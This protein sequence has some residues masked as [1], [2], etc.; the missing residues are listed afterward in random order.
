MATFHGGQN[1]VGTALHRQVQVADQLRDFGVYL[2]QAVA[3]FQ[4]MRGGETDAVDAIDIR[5][6]GNEFGQISDIAVFGGAT[7]GVYVLTQQVYFAHAL[8]GQRLHFFQH[9]GQRAADFLTAGVGHHAEGTVF[10]A[11]FHNGDEGAAAIHFRF[12]QV[13]EF[14][15]FRKGNVHHLN[16]VG[17]FVHHIRQAVQGLR[18][19][20]H[21]DERCALDNG[22]AFLRGHTA[23]HTDLQ[24]R[25]FG[26]Q[27]FPASQLMEHFFLRF[28]TD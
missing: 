11:A 6:Q 1:A 19:E 21:V 12:R 24:I 23:T 5:H 26:F 10:G 9:I 3:E 15:D 2:N 7:V 8:T 14:F 20:H 13:V 27:A 4:R 28:F 16:G 17:G 25:I 22:I 18:T